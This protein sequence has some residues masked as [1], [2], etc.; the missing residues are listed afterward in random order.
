MRALTRMEINDICEKI[1]EPN[2]FCDMYKTIQENVDAF[3]KYL[4]DI[5]VQNGSDFW[6][7]CSLAIRSKISAQVSFEVTKSLF[8]K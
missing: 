3:E 5:G 4:L 7:V 6:Y 1:R 2:S 8:L